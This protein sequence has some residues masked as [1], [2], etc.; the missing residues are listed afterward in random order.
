MFGNLLLTI[1]W[2]YVYSAKTSI[3]KVTRLDEMTKEMVEI[4]FPEVTVKYKNQDLPYITAQLKKMSRLKKKEYKKNGRSEKYKRMN[5]EY[6]KKLKE[7]S[8]RYLEKNVN[9]IKGTNPAKAARILRTLG[10]DPGNVQDKGFTLSNHQEAGLSVEEQRKEILQFFAKVSQEYL[11]LEEDRLPDEVR[12]KISKGKLPETIPFLDHIS[13]ME[14][15]RLTKHTMSK[16]PG[17]MPPSIRQEFYQWLAEPYRDILL[18]IVKSG[19]W[20]SQW[21]REFGT[22]IPKEKP[23]LESEE[24]LRVISITNKLSMTSEKFLLKWIWPYVSRKL[25]RDQFG[26]MS[27]NSVSHYLIEVANAI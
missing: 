9:L 7:E 19:Q 3:D 17:D 23:P 18:E 10:A 24:Q 21:K 13:I 5:S 27:D 15:L 16:A 12:E 25:D 1:S 20:P 8:A 11:P 2:D 26:G 6:K 4:C 22:P 14:A